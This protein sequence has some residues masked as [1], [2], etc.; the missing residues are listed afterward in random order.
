MIDL[1]KNIEI[2]VSDTLYL[3]DP[4]SSKLGKSIIS[5]SISLFEEY[6]VEAF[7]FKKLSEKV[8]T[9]ESSIYRYFENKYKL[10]MYLI[11]WYINFLEHKLA[12]SIAN[13]ENPEDKLKFALKIII[14]NEDI[15]L[16]EMNLISLQKILIFE[17]NKAL[18]FKQLGVTSSAFEAYNSLCKRIAEIII[19]INSD[20]KYPESLSSLIFEGIYHQKLLEY[21]NNELCNTKSFNDIEEFFYNLT[22]KTIS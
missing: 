21:R 22:I 19:L 16:P 10:L 1:L 18:L 17:S 3:K 11:S 6:G 15:N 5:A 8:N 9:T 2:Q 13:I 14:R 7:T 12:F 20:Y 4:K